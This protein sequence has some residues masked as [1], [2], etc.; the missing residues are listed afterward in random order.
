MGSELRRLLTSLGAED[1]A[2]W[3]CRVDGEEVEA[4]VVELEHKRFGLL[5]W[6]NTAAGYDSWGFQELGG[7][8]SVLVP[9]VKTGAGELLIGVVEQLRPFQ[10][11]SP[12]LNLPRGFLEL[13]LSHFESAVAE[14]HEEFAVVEGERVFAPPGEPGNPNSTF[15]VTLGE[16]NGVKYYGVQFF[17]DEIAEVGGKY[18]LNLDV[19][20]ATSAAA[21]K[22]TGSQFV[23]WQVAATV[24][25]QFTNSGAVRLM[26]KIVKGLQF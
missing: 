13:G 24:G 12:I 3:K 4:S 1:K 23:P 20:K 15:F 5:R 26:A 18:V 16:E 14:L 11:E 6:G 2:G 19:V 17:E 9:F 7:G 8:G 10:S 21:E 22:I 25:D